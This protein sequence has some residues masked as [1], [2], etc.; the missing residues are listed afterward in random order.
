MPPHLPPH[1]RNMRSHIG[2]TR[3]GLVLCVLCPLCM[4]HPIHAVA[5]ASRCGWPRRRWLSGTSKDTGSDRCD[6]ELNLSRPSV[7]G[8]SGGKWPS[9]RLLSPNCIVCPTVGI[10]LTAQHRMCAMVVG[11]LSE[12]IVTVSLRTE[13]M[14]RMFRLQNKKCSETGPNRRFSGPEQYQKQFRYAL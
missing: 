3:R 14:L 7:R 5:T 1:T 4:H 2:R 10:M 11:A 9:L 13:K 8:I 12:S 6:M